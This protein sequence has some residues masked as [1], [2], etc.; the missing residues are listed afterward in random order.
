MPTFLSCASVG[1]IE[2]G[3]IDE[4]PPH[5]IASTPD[6][7]ALNNTKKKISI[8]FDEYIKLEKANEKVVISPPQVQQPE[9]KANGKRVVVELQDSLKSNTTYTIDFADAIQDNNEGNVLPDFSFTFST[10]TVIDSME[11]ANA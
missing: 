7:G 9:I 3:P 2:G 10:G 4:A 8:L 11:K 5:F 6:P 1:R